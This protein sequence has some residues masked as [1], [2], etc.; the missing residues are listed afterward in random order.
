MYIT[1]F[2]IQY[3]ALK[4]RALRGPQVVLPA[5]AAALVAPHPLK[6]LAYS[7]CCRPFV[8]ELQHALREERVRDDLRGPRNRLGGHPPFNSLP[9]LNPTKSTRKY[10]KNYLKRPNTQSDVLDPPVNSL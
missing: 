6:A 9:H 2:D 4:W 1:A 8:E 5:G 3:S 7:W 10:V